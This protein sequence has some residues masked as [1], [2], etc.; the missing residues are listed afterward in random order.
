[1]PNEVT[2][3]VDVPVYFPDRK[4]KKHRNQLYVRKT[5]T[6]NEDKKMNEALL[7]IELVEDYGLDSREALAIVLEQDPDKAA[8]KMAKKNGNGDPD[9]EKE[10]EA[11]YRETMKKK[12]KETGKKGAPFGGKK[13]PPFKKKNGKD[14]DD[15]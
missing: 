1:M 11:K 2:T 13:A 14:D 4:K 7:A 3:T 15:E 10:L 8:K 6:K 5:R 12:M 9:K